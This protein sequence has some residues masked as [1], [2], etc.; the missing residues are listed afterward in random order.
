MIDVVGSTFNDIVMVPSPTS[1][2]VSINRCQDPSKDVLLE[3]YAPWCGHCKSLAPVYKKLAKYV[4]G[5]KDL[6]IAKIDGTANYH[7][8][9]FEVSGSVVDSVVI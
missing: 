7:P 9:E 3:F 4:K 8:P 6:V 5:V 1:V 2:S